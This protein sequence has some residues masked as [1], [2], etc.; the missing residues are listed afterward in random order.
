MRKGLLA[1][2][3]GEVGVKSQILVDDLLAET[4]RIWDHSQIDR[5]LPEL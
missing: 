3:R 1:N 4:T 2:Y 5:R